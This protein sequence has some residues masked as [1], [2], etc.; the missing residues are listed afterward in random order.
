MLTTD[1][2][3]C[4]QVTSHAGRRRQKQVGGPG[5]SPSPRPLRLALIADRCEAPGD[6]Q[7]SKAHR[8]R[9]GTERGGPRRSSAHEQNQYH[10]PALVFSPGIPARSSV[11]PGQAKRPVAPRTGGTRTRPGLVVVSGG[12]PTHSAGMVGSGR[13]QG[14]TYM[15]IRPV[16]G[17][18][19]SAASASPAQQLTRLASTVLQRPDFLSPTLRS[20]ATPLAHGRRSVHCPPLGRPGHSCNG[21]RDKGV[22]T[23][24]AA[25]FRASPALSHTHFVL[26]SPHPL[27]S[28]HNAYN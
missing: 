1:L 15:Q 11:R 19:R 8:A 7:R 21:M 4:G 14:T 20:P 5:R 27:F 9:H 3:K 17:C 16:I 23:A 12:G 25:A 26:T 2:V 28:A 6:S 13:D 22:G 10:A 18:V 24:N